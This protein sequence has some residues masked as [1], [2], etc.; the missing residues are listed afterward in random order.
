M[1]RANYTI[2]GQCLKGMLKGDLKK[3]FWGMVY[4]FTPGI[5][6]DPEL[7]KKNKNI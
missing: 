1:S 6:I 7:K 2:Y 3:I 5:E 4:I